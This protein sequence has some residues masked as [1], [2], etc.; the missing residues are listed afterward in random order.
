MANV[1]KR[2][3]V[4]LNPD[5]HAAATKLAESVNLSVSHFI[6]VLIRAASPEPLPETTHHAR[7]HAEKARASKSARRAATP[8]EPPSAIERVQPPIRM[9]KPPSRA[10]PLTTTERMRRHYLSQNDPKRVPSPALVRG[11]Y[12]EARRA[13]GN[14]PGPSD[15]RGASDT[16]FQSYLRRVGAEFQ[17]RLKEAGIHVEG[18][19]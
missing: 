2:R 17:R 3:G 18:A 7:T 15:F 12:R 6:E 16:Q 8:I 10:M 1:Q 14:T 19:A 4:S 9:S 5:I 11:I 13:I